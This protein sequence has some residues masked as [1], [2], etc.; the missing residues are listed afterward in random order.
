MCSGFSLYIYIYIIYYIIK[1]GFKSRSCAKWFYQIAEIF[2]DF[3]ILKY[4]YYFYSHK[5]K[6]LFVLINFNKII[7]VF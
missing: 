7:K 6:S 2:L 4:I 1:I 5:N 3:F